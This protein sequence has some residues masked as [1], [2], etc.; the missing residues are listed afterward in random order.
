VGCIRALERDRVRGAG[1]K[2]LFADVVQLVRHAIGEADE[3]RPYREE[4]ERRYFDWL[5]AQER[6]GRTFTPEQLEWLALIRD[7]VAVNLDVQPED[8]WSSPFRERGGVV[9]AS[10]IFGGED[11]KRILSEI[12]AALA[13]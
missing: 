12:N 11:F 13:A 10:A 6:N 8:F 5:A 4:V 1:E 9:R 2:R 3:L 7:H